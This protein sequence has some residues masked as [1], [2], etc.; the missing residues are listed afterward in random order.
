MKLVDYDKAVEMIE[1]SINFYK[2]LR[3][4]YPLLIGDAT[5]NIFACESFKEILNECLIDEVK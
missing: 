5:R 4:E 1:E 3:K 2:G